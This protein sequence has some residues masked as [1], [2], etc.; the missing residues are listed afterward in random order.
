MVWYAWHD[1]AS[2][3]KIMSGHSNIFDNEFPW[4]RERPKSV[5]YLRLKKAKGLQSVKVFSFTVPKKPKSWTELARQGER[6]EIFP[7]SVANH[8]HFFG[9]CNIHCCKTSKNWRGTLW[10]KFFTKKSLTTPK[11]TERGTLWDF[12]RPFCCKNERAIWRKISKKSRTI[13][14]KNWKWWPFSLVR[15][16]M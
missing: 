9:F 1:H 15:Y 12:Q 13:P 11:K 7:H 8:R 5:P 16:C 10:G 2:I 6:F 3:G 14:K 4:I